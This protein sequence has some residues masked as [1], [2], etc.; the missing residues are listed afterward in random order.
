M[1]NAGEKPRNEMI[2][3]PFDFVAAHDR[4]V[5]SVAVAVPPELCHRPNLMMTKFTC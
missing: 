2:Q 4:I 1:E 5:L 3:D